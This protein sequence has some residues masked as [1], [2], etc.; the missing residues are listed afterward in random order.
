MASATNDNLTF[1]IENKKCFIEAS[2]DLLKQKVLELCIAETFAKIRIQCDEVDQSD[3]TNDIKKSKKDRLFG[4]SQWGLKMQKDLDDM[5]S[6][7]S[8]DHT[9][10]STQIIVSKEIDRLLNTHTFPEMLH[11]I[12]TQMAAAKQII[13]KK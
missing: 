11:K 10:E 5:K 2:E 7:K 6:G 12:N 4:M 13:N 9:S 1:L 3:E 8:F